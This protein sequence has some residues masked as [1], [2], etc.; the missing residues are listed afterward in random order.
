MLWKIVHI[1]DFDCFRFNPDDGSILMSVKRKRIACN[2]KKIQRLGL[3]FGDLIEFNKC[4]ILLDKIFNLIRK[5][6]T[7]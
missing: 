5:N 6:K 3:K 4:L 1:F 2:K 7:L